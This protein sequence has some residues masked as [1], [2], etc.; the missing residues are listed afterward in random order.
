[1]KCCEGVQDSRTSAFMA[2]LSV[3]DG[4][5]TR[6]RRSSHQSSSW[7]RERGVER[8]PERDFALFRGT[9]TWGEDDGLVSNERSVGM[10]V[11]IGIL[12]MVC[13][14]DEEIIYTDHSDC[15]G[16]NVNDDN[17]CK[18]IGFTERTMASTAGTSSILQGGSGEEIACYNEECGHA[19]RRS[20]QCNVQVLSTETVNSASK[21]RDQI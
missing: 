12:S 8:A 16:G 10:S 21:I 9:N 7:K 20:Y 11:L 4:R 5:G 17:S 3:L 2:G 6:K 13:Q 19:E 18:R 1:M 14:N 15:A